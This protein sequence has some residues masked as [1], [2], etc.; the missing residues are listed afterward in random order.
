MA[1]PT[2]PSIS[3]AT[4]EDVPAVLTMINELAVYE[5]EEPATVQATEASLRR[6]LTFPTSSTSHTNPGYAKT[7]LLRLPA[8]PTK[9]SYD[10]YPNDVAGA[11]VGMAMYFNNYSTWRAKPG[12]YLEDLFVK[13]EYR[14]RGYGKLLI[15]EL[16]REVLRI[17]GGRLE[18][19]CLRWNT[20]SL[21]FYDGLGAERMEDWI[22]LRVEGEALEKLA[23]GRPLEQS[24]TEH[25][26]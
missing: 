11:V 9:K 25:E 13:P 3:F 8:T 14:G 26:V 21:K 7:L 6:T 19:S 24:E 10:K 15:Q 4:T 23:L 22:G 16:A 1:N 20:P 12:V 18:W 2:Q 17:D 5:K